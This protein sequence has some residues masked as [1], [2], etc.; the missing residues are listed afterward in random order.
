M[1]AT[2]TAA[3]LA[4]FACGIGAGALFGALKPSDV[5]RPFFHAAAVLLAPAGLLLALVL[6]A[7][8]RGNQRAELATA[9][10]AAELAKAKADELEAEK[11]I[12]A[13]ERELA[14]EAASRGR[15]G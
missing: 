4:W 7:H 6:T 1:T 14:Q 3:V 8:R 11:T 9:R 15:A 2:I 5:D 10:H 12:K 13:V